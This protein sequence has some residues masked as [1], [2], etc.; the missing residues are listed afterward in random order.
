[1]KEIIEMSE[2]E[3]DRHHIIQKVVDKQITQ[4][5]AA[6][7]LNLKSDRQVRNLL[8]NYKK[9]GI[10]GL[11]SKQRGKPSNRAVDSKRK[12]QIM[13]LIREKYPDFGPTF[14]AEKLKEY[15][16]IT[17]SE[18]TLRKWMIQENLWIPRKK[19][20]PYPPFTTTARLFWRIDTNRCF[21]SLLV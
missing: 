2:R 13:A 7:L 4:K 20:H 17:I 1:M 11:I 10:K 8:S 6:E 15:H 14:A 18:E 9:Q 19:R 5:K 3:L 12:K 21:S 16:G